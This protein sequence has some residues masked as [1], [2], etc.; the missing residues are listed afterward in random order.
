MIT[1][2]TPSRPGDTT[3]VK[4]AFPKAEP[5]CRPLSARDT[6]PEVS[7]LSVPKRILA[8]PAIISAFFQRRSDPSEDNVPKSVQ[9]A[10]V[11]DHDG[12]SENEI[13][14]D[15][16]CNLSRPSNTKLDK[17][18]FP[19]GEPLCLPLNIPDSSPEMTKASPHR[20]STPPASDLSPRPHPQL[21]AAALKYVATTTDLENDTELDDQ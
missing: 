20:P 9:A 11:Q 17:P 15:G 18:A 12:P 10:E 2:R 4:P 14:M 16:S 13:R 3:L 6:T 1:P 8:I 7:K 21:P 5:L 19:K